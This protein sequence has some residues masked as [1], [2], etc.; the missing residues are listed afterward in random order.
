LFFG[1]LMAAPIG[2]KLRERSARWGWIML[3]GGPIA[4][5][6]I[7]PSIFLDRVSVNT[8]GFSRRSGFFGATAVQDVKFSELT[9][10]RLRAEAERGRRGRRVTRYYLYCDQKNGESTKL[11]LGNDVCEAAIR[12]ILTAATASGVAIADQTGGLLQ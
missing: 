7:A 3:I 12:Q 2:W 10:M 4:A 5:L 9:G 1:G 6:L 11:P 8:E